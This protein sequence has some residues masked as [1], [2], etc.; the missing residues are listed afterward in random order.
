[1]NRVATFE[2][3]QAVDALVDLLMACAEGEVVTW[4]AMRLATNR[5]ITGRERHLVQSA[6]R[7]ALRKGA[8]FGTVIGGGLK[9]LRPN[10]HTPEGQRRVKLIG[11]A[12]RRGE[13][14]VAAADVAR[15]EPNERLAHANTAAV[16]NALRSQARRQPEQKHR[17]GNADPVVVVA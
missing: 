16:L 15:L 14:V 2:R 1:M 11:R 17:G 4:D 8:A 12:A 10:E 6:R 7:I 5:D 13:C 3:S 9:R